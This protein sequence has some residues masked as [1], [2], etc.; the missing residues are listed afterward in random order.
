MIVCYIVYM[1]IRTFVFNISPLS[2]SMAKLKYYAPPV[3][4]FFVGM[5]YSQEEA[6][7]KRLWILTIVIGSFACLYGFKQLYMGYSIAER[8]W[9][10]SISLRR[11][12]SKGLRGVF[13]FSGSGGLCGLICSSAYMRHSDGSS[14][15]PPSKKT[16]AHGSASHFFLW[17]PYHLSPLELDDR[18]AAVLYLLVRHFKN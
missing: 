2:E 5:L 3:L 10:S 14:R 15:G 4:L 11:S 9:F 17:D 16:A 18:R 6:H 13:F 12:L 7:L 1:I 8:L